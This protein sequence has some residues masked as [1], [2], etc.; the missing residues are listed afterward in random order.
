MPPVADAPVQHEDAQM[1]SLRQISDVDVGSSSGKPYPTNTPGRRPPTHHQ[2][3]HK[4]PRHHPPLGGR[5]GPTPIGAGG[6]GVTRAGAGRARPGRRVWRERRA[7][8]FFH[9]MQT[10][11]YCMVSPACRHAPTSHVWAGTSDLTQDAC[12][13]EL[14]L[15]RMGRRTPKS[16]SA[17]LWCDRKETARGNISPPTG[18]TSRGS[19]QTRASRLERRGSMSNE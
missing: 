13:T 19:T 1:W 11:P 14:L 12:V 9:V 5:V 6:R 15:G 7:V 17:F 16:N 10:R 4:N 3:H 2:Q 18:C 8:G